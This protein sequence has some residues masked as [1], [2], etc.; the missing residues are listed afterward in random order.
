MAG[1]LAVAISCYPPDRRK[2]DLDNILKS[3]L[4]ALCYSQVIV[5]DSCIDVLSIRRMCISA[6]GYVSVSITHNHEDIPW[7]HAKPTN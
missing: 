2:R 1:S 3:L 4:D 5:D 6:P 7:P